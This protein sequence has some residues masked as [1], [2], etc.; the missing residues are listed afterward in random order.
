MQNNYVYFH[1]DPVT[2]E[3][4]YIGHG[5]YDRAWIFKASTLRDKQHRTH[6]ITLFNN[7]YSP[8]DWVK[9]KKRNLEKSEACKLER[10]MILK[11]NPKYNKLKGIGSIR[12]RGAIVLKAIQLRKMGLSYA[13][14]K[15][16]L[17]ISSS[18]T[19]WRYINE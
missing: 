9:I 7:G 13:E 8:F 4:L 16:K 12:K 3:I 10:E 15:N 19:A 6:L 5:T 14:I 2:R 17:N 1:V 18:M 11:Y